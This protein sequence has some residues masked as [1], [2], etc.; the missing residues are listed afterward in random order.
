MY[1]VNGS[2][3]IITGSAQGLGK[4]FAKRLLQDGCK[5]CISDVDEV[6]GLE[7][8]LQFQ[9]Q[10]GLGDDGVCFVKCDVTQK[11][12]WTALWESAEK[13]LNDNFATYALGTFDS[14]L[15]GSRGHHGCATAACGAGVAAT[16]PGWDHD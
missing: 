15:S 2:R 16:R 5:V 1:D 12:D 4:E 6:K 11:E 9:K 3:A 10:F 7:T 8:K 14:S 13:I